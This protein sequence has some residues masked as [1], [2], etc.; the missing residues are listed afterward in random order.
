MIVS[1]K[2]PSRTTSTCSARAFDDP[3]GQYGAGIEEIIDLHVL[4]RIVA[5]MFVADEEHRGRNS[6]S[7]ECGGIARLDSPAACCECP[8]ARPPPSSPSR[9][10]DR[11]RRRPLPPV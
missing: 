8:D 6:R 10:P 3:V 11:R 7:G 9:W 5:A 1:F 2:P 4:L